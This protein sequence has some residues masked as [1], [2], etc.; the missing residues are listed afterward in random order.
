MDI[1]YYLA[2]FEEV[3]SQYQTAQGQ[4][5]PSQSSVKH[6]TLKGKGALTPT[7]DVL[8]DLADA[9]KYKVRLI[10]TDDVDNQKVD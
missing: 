3:S 10:D 4:V 7:D 2:F 6:D 1:M 9:P 8:I 5:S